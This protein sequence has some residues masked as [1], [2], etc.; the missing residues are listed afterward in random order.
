M[1]PYPPALVAGGPWSF[2]LLYM[3]CHVSKTSPPRVI[4]FPPLFLSLLCSRMSP[5]THTVKPKSSQR[6]QVP[7][8]S[9]CQ[10]SPSP[11]VL[12]YWS[13]C[14]STDVPGM[15]LPRDLCALRSPCLESSSPDSSGFSLSLTRSGHLFSAMHTHTP[16]IPYLPPAFLP[17]HTAYCPDYLFILFN[18]YL[19]SPPPGKLLQGVL[20]F[21]YRCILIS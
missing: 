14:C 13:H 16:D 19:P 18:A 17:P 20:C 9:G 15:P 2:L 8:W 12:A 7:A 11:S 10:P 21:L 4:L 5:H 1:P 6:H 3:D